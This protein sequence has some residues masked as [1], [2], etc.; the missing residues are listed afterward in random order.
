MAPVFRPGQ[1]A[2]VL[3]RR[4]SGPDAAVGRDALV[5]LA[6]GRVCCAG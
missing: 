6:D 5:E 2:L 4:P 1:I 3:A